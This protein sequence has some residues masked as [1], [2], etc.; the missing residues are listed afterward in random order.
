MDLDQVDKD[1]QLRIFIE[2][3]VQGMFF[4]EVQAIEQVSPTEFIINQASERERITGFD[5]CEQYRQD[6]DT[7]RTHRNKCSFVLVRAYCLSEFILT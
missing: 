2:E 1:K 5:Q 4:F 7:V 3:Y 6:G